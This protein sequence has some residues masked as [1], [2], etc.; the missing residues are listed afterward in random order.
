MF[1]MFVSYYVPYYVSVFAISSAQKEIIGSIQAGT[2]SRRRQQGSD[3][4]D[5]VE[6][7]LSASF[8]VPASRP[9]GFILFDFWSSYVN[10]LLNVFLDISTAH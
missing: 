3:S 7:P 9:N 2:M 4:E 10:V 6:V 8:A 1:H 5:V